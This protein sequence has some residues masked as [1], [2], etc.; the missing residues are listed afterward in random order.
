[1]HRA[2]C[3]WAGFLCRVPTGRHFRVSHISPS[4]H[5]PLSC[6]SWQCSPCRAQVPAPSKHSAELSFLLSSF[7][8][9]LNCQPL[10]PRLRTASPTA[11]APRWLFHRT[12]TF[13]VFGPAAFHCHYLTQNTICGFVWDWLCFISGLLSSVDTRYESRAKSRVAGHQLVCP[14]W[15]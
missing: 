3:S 6:G 12:P 9:P 13:Q 11:T 5:C 10:L 8:F 7:R 15:E 14:G 1:M 2:R 4:S